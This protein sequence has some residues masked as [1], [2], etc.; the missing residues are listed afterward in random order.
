VGGVLQVSEQDV[1]Q[2]RAVQEALEYLEG[3]SSTVPGGGGGG[4]VAS[5]GADGMAGSTTVAAA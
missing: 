4:G 5:G 3:Y 1:Q 2:W